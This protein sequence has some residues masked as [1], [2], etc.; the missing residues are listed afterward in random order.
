MFVQGTAWITDPET[1]EPSIEGEACT[2]EAERTDSNEVRLGIRI[3][4]SATN[5]DDVTLYVTV[6]EASGL[7]HMLGV[8]CLAHEAA[9]HF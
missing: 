2:A 5:G 9:A 4:G 3:G 7:A 8:A 6:A 1:G